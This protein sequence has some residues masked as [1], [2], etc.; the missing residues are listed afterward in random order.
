MLR[1]APIVLLL[2][3]CGD[4]GHEPGPGEVTISEAKAIDDAA[5]MLDARGEP[6][7]EPAAAVKE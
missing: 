1:L 5:A 3:A 4:T 6:D 7:A 2:A